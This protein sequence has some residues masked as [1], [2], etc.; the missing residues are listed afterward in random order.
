LRALS[1]RINFR[2]LFFGGGSRKESNEIIVWGQEKQNNVSRF[3]VREA[4][5][6]WPK[7]RAKP[8]FWS[9]L[10]VLLEESLLVSSMHNSLEPISVWLFS[11]N[12]KCSG[13]GSNPFTFC[14]LAKQFWFWLDLSP[15]CRG[16]EAD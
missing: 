10:L 6:L 5:R 9:F 11:C 4:S 3:K 12:C 8:V 1:T 7:G 16:L 15:K 13:P 2:S 14:F